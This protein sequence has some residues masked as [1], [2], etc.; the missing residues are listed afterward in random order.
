LSAERE[1]NRPRSR[2]SALVLDPPSSSFP[3]TLAE[4]SGKDSPKMSQERETGTVKWFNAQKGYGFIERQGGNDVFVHHSEIEGEG[5][6]EL[7]EGEKVTFIVTQGQK[8]PQAS[9]VRRATD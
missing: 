2:I 5:Y 1:T 8:G 7:R 6:R 4:S 3:T 9:Q